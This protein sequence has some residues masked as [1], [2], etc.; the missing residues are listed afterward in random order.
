MW[1]PCIFIPPLIVKP[2]LLEAPANIQYSPALN[3]Q[4]QIARATPLSQLFMYM[5]NSLSKV[6]KAL[7]NDFVMF[8]FWSSLVLKGL[9]YGNV[10]P[11]PK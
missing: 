3:M 4:R 1:L 7:V 5:N 9:E 11:R 2:L 6:V 8:F 10:V